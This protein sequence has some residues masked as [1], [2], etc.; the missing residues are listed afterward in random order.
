MTAKR[1]PIPIWLLF[2]VVILQVHT[3]RA[4][5]VT[6]VAAGTYYSLFL[7]G[8][9]SLWAM[10][11]NNFGQLGDGTYNNTN[12]PEQIVASNVTAI[13][14]S[15]HSLFLKSDGSL[16]AMGNNASGQL[17]DGTYATNAPYYGTNLPEQIVA[18]NVRAIAAGDGFSLFL[19]NDGSLWA[20]G[21]NNSGQLGDGTYNRT[22]LPE[23]IVSSNVTAIAAGDTFSLFLKSDGSLWAMGN[24][25]SGQ[26]GDGTYATNVPYY[27]TN[28]P[29]Q[30]V[31][32]NVMAISAGEGHSL[33]LKNDGSLWAMGFNGDGQLGDDTYNNTNRPEQIMASNVT[34]ISAGAN[35][36]LFLKSDGSLWAMGDNN[37]GELGD[38]TVPNWGFL[39]HTTTNFPEQIVA[40][41]VTTICGGSF[42]LMWSIGP[43]TPGVHS[44]FAKSDGSLWAMGDDIYGELGDGTNY[45]VHSTF[46]PNRPEQ[47]VAGRPGYNQI[48]VQLLSRGDVSLSFVGI[49]GANYAL[50]S[51]FSLSSP[52]WLPLATNAADVNGI[53]VFT[54]T[55]DPTTCNFWRIHS[56][57]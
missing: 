27:G 29:E 57:P 6:K 32:S 8:D 50:D 33:F 42:S 40:G 53:L 26:L 9:G 15:D 11:R 30:I 23:Q 17:G 52:N 48:S 47:I 12:R 55:P 4:Q 5:P 19:K 41:N 13:A 43:G 21:Y 20:M 25:A 54:N 35:Y 38:G 45:N 28:V 24:N 18:S 37:F 56:V 34:A 51:S 49:A 16:W 36:S 39:S 22:N 31:A 7:K 3:G 10:G 44:L 1:N 46:G 14:A 2:I